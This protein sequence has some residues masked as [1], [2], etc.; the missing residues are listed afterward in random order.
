MREAR[1][2]A[3]ADP[4]GRTLDQTLARS[5]IAPRPLK[6]YPITFSRPAV[7]GGQRV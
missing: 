1:E 6:A 7:R 3:L 4:D 2:A 5:G